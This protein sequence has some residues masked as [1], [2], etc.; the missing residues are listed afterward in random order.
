MAETILSDEAR[1]FW[2]EVSK[3]YGDKKTNTLPKI[4]DGEMSIEHISGAFVDKYTS[5]YNAV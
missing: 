3:V 2:N 4:I 1:S 5:L